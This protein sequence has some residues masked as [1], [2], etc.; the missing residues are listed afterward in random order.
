[1]VV[2][3]GTTAEK[4]AIDSHYA[5]EMDSSRAS[6]RRCWQ[7]KKKASRP[8]DVALFERDGNLRCRHGCVETRR[9]NSRQA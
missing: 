7:R 2:A 8:R 5:R 1:M 4:L 3:H 9:R 6:H